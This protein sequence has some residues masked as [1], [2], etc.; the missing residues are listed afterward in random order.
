MLRDTSAP[1][2]RDGKIILWLV[3][4]SRARTQIEEFYYQGR[5][6]YSAESEKG[7]GEGDTDSHDG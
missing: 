3:A 6:E 1:I 7:T 5:D 4:F 2:G